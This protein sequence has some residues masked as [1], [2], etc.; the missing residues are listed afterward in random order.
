[1]IRR[2]A[3]LLLLITLMLPALPASAGAGASLGGVEMG[4]VDGDGNGL[5]EGLAALTTLTVNGSADGSYTVKG[6]LRPY[7]GP[8]DWVT[9]AHL[10]GK[11]SAGSYPVRLFFD[12]SPAA[13]A[14]YG[15]RF[16]VTLYLYSQDGTLLSSV[17][18]LS[19]EFPAGSIEA[20]GGA[21]KGGVQLL[22][23]YEEFPDR[24]ANGLYDGVMLT[25]SANITT[26]GFYIVGA[27]L[28][29]TQVSASIGSY[30][31]SG[32]QKVQRFLP[33]GAIY[34][35]GFSGLFVYKVWVVPD[36]GLPPLAE[37][38][39]NGT[40]HN[41]TEF[42]APP[43]Y[44][45]GNLTERLVDDN[46]NGFYELLVVEF[47]LNVTSAGAY[48]VSGKLAPAAPLE[49]PVG[50]LPVDVSPSAFAEASGKYG[51]GTQRVKLPFPG[52]ALWRMQSAGPYEIRI[53]VFA[54]EK[55]GVSEAGFRVKGADWG[56]FERPPL[57]VRFI[58]GTGRDA[59]VDAN[60]NGRFEALAVS[61]GVD[62]RMGGRY[63]L[64][65]ELITK[66]TPFAWYSAPVDLREGKSE[67]KVRFD[68]GA[69]FGAGLDGPYV[70]L[71][72]LAPVPAY[73]TGGPGVAPPPPEPFARMKVV[74]GN[75]TA[76]SFEGPDGAKGAASGAGR[77]LLEE[78]PGWI[79]ARSDMLTAQVL[80]ERP[81]IVF[82]YTTDSGESARFR[83]SFVRLI[84]FRDADGDGVFSEGEALGEAPLFSAAWKVE[85]PS[86]GVDSVSYNMTAEVG[87]TGPSAP[88]KEGTRPWGRVTL[89]FTF[90]TG[91]RNVTAPGGGA[92]KIGGGSELK[93]DIRLEPYRGTKAPMVALEMALHDERQMHRIELREG[94]GPRLLAPSGDA[95]VSGRFADA[96]GPKQL[97][98]FV[99]RER[100]E[101]SRGFFAWASSAEVAGGNWA[102]VNASFAADGKALL[103]RLNYPAPE[104]GSY[105]FHDPSI[106]VEAANAPRVV[107]VSEPQGVFSPLVYLFA[108]VIGVMTVYGI[109]RSQVGA[110]RGGR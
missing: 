35:S 40:Y 14:K 36:G 97:I 5:Y 68:G 63:M 65:G 102:P 79:Q 10:S 96:P 22:G 55:D 69:I 67:V 9:G 104:A 94:T 75:Y 83:L 105:I 52:E 59:G 101:R 47:D 13:G 21:A 19:A 50:K 44:I 64:S 12:L 17:E 89:T 20:M 71:L 41:Y 60:G 2:S 90:T 109:G 93:I 15:G 42:Q 25:V 28:G 26:P 76:K 24:D 82:Y 72:T 33:G 37:A 56:R 30:L 1:M 57:P 108:L 84:L 66:R 85:K 74:T 91:D 103:L 99:T 88:E 38:A 49:R 61:A 78:G 95:P 8:D 53:V 4:G 48:R 11:F 3:A 16:Q 18:A 29:G 43:A 106:G 7:T 62:A 46:G 92:F 27:A 80:T 110:R 58:E 86:V 6:E 100:S 73:D 45:A 32:P 98:A 70:A 34:L 77:I 87:G 81:E 23:M 31:G 51:A 39:F 54:G 107:T